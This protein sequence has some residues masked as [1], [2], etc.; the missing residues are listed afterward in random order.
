MTT[1]QA[2][3]TTYLSTSCGFWRVIH[4]GSPLSPD[5]ATREDSIEVPRVLSRDHHCVNVLGW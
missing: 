5:R 4:Q 3:P 1:D 2:T